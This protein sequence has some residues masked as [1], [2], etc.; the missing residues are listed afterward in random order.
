MV[1][2]LNAANSNGTDTTK[3]KTIPEPYKRYPGVDY[4]K[5]MTLGLVAI[6]IDT[7]NEAEKYADKTR[8]H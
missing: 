8:K 5:I 3:M 2:I 7:T 4:E 1:K 6:S